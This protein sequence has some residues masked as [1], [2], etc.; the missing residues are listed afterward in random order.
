MITHLP[1]R[2]SSPFLI[3]CAKQ[4]HT[5]APKKGCIQ[6][7]LDNGKNAEI[8]CNGKDQVE[9]KMNELCQKRFRS[10]CK[11]WLENY[12]NFIAKL[13]FEYEMATKSAANQHYLRVA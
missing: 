4:G 9:Y 7:K 10:F 1:H 5:V 3:W 12:D 13:N 8:Y 6:I 11:E 2:L